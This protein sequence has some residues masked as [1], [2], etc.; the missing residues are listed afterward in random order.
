[1]KNKKQIFLYIVPIGILLDQFT[2]VLI[3]EKMNL[4]QDLAP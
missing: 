1:M 3:A 2:K 4:H